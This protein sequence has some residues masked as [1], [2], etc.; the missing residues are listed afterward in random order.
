MTDQETPT[1][2]IEFIPRKC[3]MESLERLKG[4]KGP[5]QS[6][7]GPAAERPQ[8]ETAEDLR[9]SLAVEPAAQQSK[10]HHCRGTGLHRALTRRLI[11]EISCPE[12]GG[13]GE[14]SGRLNAGVLP[15]GTPEGSQHD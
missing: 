3:A 4:V 12:C 14:R 5:E 10:C 15:P 11:T 1:N 6:L 7:V 8:P 2:V 13:T 9:E